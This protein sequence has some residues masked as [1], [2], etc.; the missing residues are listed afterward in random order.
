MSELALSK[1]RR[2]V[3]LGQFTSSHFDHSGLPISF[4]LQLH[5]ATNLWWDVLTA[6]CALVTS[7]NR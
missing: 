6:L 5:S 2:E 4:C 1:H 3:S 7:F